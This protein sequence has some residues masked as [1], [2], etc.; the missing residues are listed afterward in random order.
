M[1][2][3]ILFIFSLLVLFS[4]LG[5]FWFLNPETS[6]MGMYGGGMREG[7]ATNVLTK[8]RIVKPYGGDGVPRET[9]LRK[10]ALD[11]F[12][13][14]ACPNGYRIASS[15]E[16]RFVPCISIAEEFKSVN[17]GK[18]CKPLAEHF[19]VYPEEGILK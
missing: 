18:L 13:G 2:K 5:F 14:G 4:L 12:G 16:C 19:P 1:E 11:S 15:Y 7:Y 17:P 10:G 6:G 3:Y 8:E 9:I